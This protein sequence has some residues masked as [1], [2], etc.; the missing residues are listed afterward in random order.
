MSLAKSLTPM[1]QQY[2]SIKN[3]HK[4]SLLF[5]RLGDFYELFY[6]DAIKA[7]KI[8]GITLTKRGQSEG[9]DIPMCGVP[10]HSH[11]TYLHKLIENGFKVAICEQTETPKPGQKGPVNRE[12][13]RIITAGT[14]TEDSLLKKEEANYLLVC[15][16]LHKGYLA[17]AL[18]D[19]STG[20]LRSELIKI[21]DINSNLHR[22]QPNEILIPEA[23][24]EQKHNFLKEWKARIHTLPY[25]RFDTSNAREIILKHFKIQT[26]DCFGQLSMEEVQ[27]CG[28][29]LDYLFITQKE[30]VKH[31]TKIHKN[32]SNQHMIIDHITQKN[33][34][35]NYTLSGKTEGSLLSIINY[36]KT[37]GGKRLLI[38]RLNSPLLNVE[39]INKRLNEIEYFFQK[40]EL[41]EKVQTFLKNF[42][43]LERCLSRLMLKRG[44]TR[45]ILCILYILNTTNNLSELLKS[46][47]DIETFN[48]L[49]TLLESSLNEHVPVHTK[50][51]GFIKPGYSKYLDEQR[52]LFT[53]SKEHI[54]S[55]AEK[56]KEKT[57]IPNLKIKFNNLLG[58]FIEITKSH[59]NKV[60]EDFIQRQS[61]VSGNRY[62]THILMELQKSILEAEE[63]AIAE[64]IKIFEALVKKVEEQI[65]KLQKLAYQISHIDNIVAL[66]HIAN[67]YHYTKPIIDDSSEFKI[68]E[69]RHPVVDIQNNFTP[70]SCM[71]NEN[72]R[73]QIITGPNM[74]G[75]STYLR[76]NALIAILAQMGSFVPAKKAHIG[77]VDRVM[78][79]IGASDAIN[80]GQSTFMVEMVETAM[81]LH[82]ATNRSLVILD[83]IGRG[84]STYD[85]LSIAWA[86][87]EYLIS[88]NKSKVLFATHYHELSELQHPSLQHLHVS[89]KEWKNQIIFLHKIQPGTMQ[90]SYG[91]HVA[92]LAG[93]PK[94]AIGKAKE[95]LK[96]L[97]HNNQKQFQPKLFEIKPSIESAIEKEIKDTDLDDLTPRQAFDLIESWKAKLNS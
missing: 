41:I 54:D 45:D 77:I 70:N 22:Y 56:Y 17:L 13:V 19:L 53:N 5:Y 89:I 63:N 31:I 71:L 80:V 30:A 96:E 74:G 1:M 40:P 33:L 65:L 81:I 44:G 18:C 34:E 95:K 84:T 83:E 26:T 35:I 42:P 4:D 92:E 38:D 12:V 16:K 55:L 94:I 68:E 73:F 43:D 11:T 79:R 10:V 97:E 57:G 24:F 20:F 91:I 88:H 23:L 78:T 47:Y 51:G 50:E 32:Y 7:A 64:E 21:E 76:Q 67:L 87:C 60:P 8:L 46:R 52:K 72:L 2:W 49:K 36:T 25:S 61:L 66:A 6:E 14:I 90:K 82:Y 37:A 28:V 86:V 9:Q 15:S 59:Q 39:K 27:A 48:D 58:Y 69:G 29:L 85:G 3:E 62:T 93:L 75:K